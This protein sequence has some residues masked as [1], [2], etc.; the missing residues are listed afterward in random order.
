MSAAIDLKGHYSLV[1]SPDDE[2]ETGKGFYAE[3]WWAD[4]IS[5]LYR[6][7]ARA[8]AWARRNGGAEAH[9]RTRS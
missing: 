1:F 7:K 6:T 3:L 2:A 4:R 9:D 8:D 5:P